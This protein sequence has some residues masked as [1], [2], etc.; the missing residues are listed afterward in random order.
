MSARKRTSG[1]RESDRNPKPTGDDDGNPVENSN[2]TPDDGRRADEHDRNE[3]DRDKDRSDRQSRDKDEHRNDKRRDDRREDQEGKEAG[4]RRDGRDGDERGDQEKEQ[5][6]DAGARWTRATE[7]EDDA[8]SL[9]AR[10]RGVDMAAGRDAT[11]FVRDVIVPGR[12]ALFTQNFFRA[13]QSVRA[14]GPIDPGDIDTLLARHVKGPAE[15][16]LEGIVTA[17]R[18]AML[19]GRPGTGRR[20]ATVAVL[21]RLTDQRHDL[22]TVQVLPAIES[23]SDA[24]QHIR[25]R[26]GHV[27]DATRATWLQSPDEAAVSHLKSVLKD[28]ASWL[29]IL[30][31]E[32]SPPE[33]FWAYLVVH[34]PPALAALT[35]SYLDRPDAETLL[36][37]ARRFRDVSAWIN[38]R[39][40]PRSAI[41]LAK[42][43]GRWEKER[44]NSAEARPDPALAHRPWVMREARLLLQPATGIRIAPRAQ[45]LVLATAVLDGERLDDV[46]RAAQQL[47]ARLCAVESPDEETGWPVF[48]PS[49]TRLL[50]HTDHADEAEPV[51]GALQDSPED[52]VPAQ[53]STD[54]PVMRTVIRLREPMLAGLL[55]EAA[56]VEYDL[57]RVP[58]L[59]WLKTLSETASTGTASRAAQAI[60]RLARLDLEAIDT[61]VLDEWSKSRRYV[62]HRNAAIVLEGAAQGSYGRKVRERVAR[63][64]R[65]RG[66]RQSIALRAMGTW[67]GQQD[68][69]RTLRDLRVPASRVDQPAT[70][71]RVIEDAV[72]ELYQAGGQDEVLAELIDWLDWPPGGR[73]RAVGCLL[74]LAWRPTNHAGRSGVPELLVQCSE[75]S[76][77]GELVST[78]WIAAL[79]HPSHAAE[80]WQ[81]LE[82][83]MSWITVGDPIAA[84]LGQLRDRLLQNE[85]TT[86]RLRLY[87]A[88][89]RVR[90]QAA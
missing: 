30:A 77:R 89:W 15:D 76:D 61:H 48:E 84:T 46:L 82:I 16:D 68:P 34:Q 51:I 85:A 44:A 21:S 45:S 72:T 47:N 7:R 18:L 56:W 20:H 6:L 9:S 39:T 62:D 78:L 60:G 65:A 5:D 55:L 32:T 23:L 53:E 42:A 26:M 24:E 33:A 41:S 87:E 49:L 12:D 38:R 52:V 66:A 54:L 36:E 71:R 63:W 13:E 29:V 81:L 8:L 79:N 86:R 37:E 27:L 11:A 83:W 43:I 22:P 59:D 28:K 50:A 80:A 40:D 3:T 35:R 74:R 88:I 57:A 14:A 1:A 2:A 73:D 10:Q 31:D 90:R 69:R 67:I 58:L 25:A 4:R 70:T 64:M 17:H 19:H 75:H